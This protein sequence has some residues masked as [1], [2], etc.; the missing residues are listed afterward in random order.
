[1]RR[2]N[3]KKQKAKQR[4]HG[5]GA[6]RAEDGDVGRKNGSLTQRV[7][8]KQNHLDSPPSLYKSVMAGANEGAASVR[9]LSYQDGGVIQQ[10]TEEEKNARHRSFNIGMDAYNKGGIN[11]LA[12]TKNSKRPKPKKSQ[13]QELQSVSSFQEQSVPGS[14]DNNLITSTTGVDEY[15]IENEN[16]DSFD[17]VPPKAPPRQKSSNRKISRNKDMMLMKRESN[18]DSREQPSKEVIALDKAEAE[19]E[20][21]LPRPPPRKSELVTVTKDEP[22]VNEAQRKAGVGV[23]TEQLSAQELKERRRSFN[24]GLDAYA[25]TNPLLG[26]GGG[27][28][29]KRRVSKNPAMMLMQQE[30]NK[31]N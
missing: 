17:V 12:K 26:K 14:S 29:P 16:D 30:N 22:E 1:M 4:T 9:P 31:S 5:S 6:R 10:L 25:K 3:K 15:E 28:G 13:L 23:T 8:E 18:N 27:K 21:S 11:I 7:G 24:I 19:A 20:A 2:L